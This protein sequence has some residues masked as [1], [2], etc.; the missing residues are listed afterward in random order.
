[1]ALKKEDPILVGEVIKRWRKKKKLSQE[2]LALNSKIDRSYIGDLETNKS[3]PS[4]Y[5]ILRIAKGLEIDP[6][7]LVNE[8]HQHNNFDQLFD[9]LK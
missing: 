5:T 8:I 3:K 6:G 2:E 7:V 1:M 9:N 4:L